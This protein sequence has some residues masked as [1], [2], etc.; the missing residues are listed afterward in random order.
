MVNSSTMTAKK[1]PKG[2]N[3]ISDNK[4]HASVKK[5]LNNSQ[6]YTKTKPR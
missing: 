2:K 3:F 5:K 6:M 1:D 4:S